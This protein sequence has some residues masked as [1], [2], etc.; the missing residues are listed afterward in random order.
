M[1]KYSDKSLL[2]QAFIA[3][4][5]KNKTKIKEYTVTQTN[6]SKELLKINNKLDVL[7]NDKLNNVISSDMYK[8]YSV[9]LKEEQK[10]IESN[11]AEITHLIENEE[12]KL[13]TLQNDEEKTNKLINKFCN[14]KNINA[15]VINEF[16]EKISIDKNRDFHIK[17]KFNL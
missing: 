1:K 13:Q 11:L 14:L 16:I 17:L 2:R 15:E 5:L 8:K 9:T 6:L 4:Y 7:Y 3:E 10:T 12:N